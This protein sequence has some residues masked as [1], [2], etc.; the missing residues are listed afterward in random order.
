VKTLDPAGL[1]AM[2]LDSAGLAA[3]VAWAIRAALARAQTKGLAEND[4]VSD[5]LHGIHRALCTHAGGT[6]VSAHIRHRVL[7][8]LLTAT[9]KQKQL[10][11]R[12]VL[13]DD[14]EDA[15]ALDDDRIPRALG[16]E[17]QVLGSPEES[18]LRHE[19]QAALDR[20]VEKLS[21]DDR[22]LYELRHREGLTW[23]EISAAT[24]IPESTLRLH[25][26]RIRARLTAALRA[27]RED[28]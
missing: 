24:G 28:G 23:P 27:Y 15:Q 16:V 17:A 19:A 2:G 1:A 6:T 11:E 10:R 4:V 5:A 18:L 9:R 3:L 12:E 21:R 26:T 25:D 7:G 13:L 14:L 8:A 20:E 22:R